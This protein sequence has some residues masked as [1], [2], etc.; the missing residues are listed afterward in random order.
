MLL[1]VPGTSTITESG[2]P[3]NESRSIHEKARAGAGVL[4]EVGA[5]DYKFDTALAEGGAK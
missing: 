5:G 2:Q 1:P 3:A 4:L